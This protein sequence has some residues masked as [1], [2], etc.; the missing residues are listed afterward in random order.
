MIK[1]LLC[2][3]LLVGTITQANVYQLTHDFLDRF[4]EIEAQE[5]VEVLMKEYISKLTIFSDYPENINVK[6]E[7]GRTALMLAVIDGNAE[8]VKLLLDRGASVKVEDDNGFTPMMHAIKQWVSVEG[9]ISYIVRFVKPVSDI[10]NPERCIDL[11]LQHGAEQLELALLKVESSDACVE[12]REY[13]NQH[14]TTLERFL[15]KFK[16]LHP[17]KLTERTVR[18]IRIHRLEKEQK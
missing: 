3:A 6:G 4:D 7:G 17:K 18:R 11:L 14:D 2:C 13:E 12:E 5:D 10:V 1:R 15:A 8:M 9:D 16:R